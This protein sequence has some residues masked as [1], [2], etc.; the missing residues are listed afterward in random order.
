M[1]KRS[2]IDPIAALREPS[3]L[4]FLVGSML[5]NTGNQ[6][7][8]AAVG[9]EVYHRTH[10]PIN[11]GYV[12][13]V[14]A[15]PVILLAMPAG[16]AADRYSRR[17]IIMIAQA[18]L[19]ISGVGLA[20]AS[21]SH[22]PLGWV[23]LFLLSTGTFRALGWPAA[24]AIVTGLVPHNVFAN[25]AMWRSVGFQLAST[26]GPLMG[27]FLIAWWNPVAIYLID[28]ASSLIL[29]GCLV[30]VRPKAHQRMAEPHSWRSL[31]QGI[32]YLRRNPVIL[33]TMTLDMVAVLFGGATALLPIYA[34]EVLHVGATG[35]GW[36]RAMPSIGAIAMSVW[37]AT[38]PPM[39]RGG[40]TLL[41]AVVAFGLATIVFGLSKSYPLSLAA[42][43]ALG[44]A[45]NVSVVIRS[46][47]L[48]LLTPDSMR[49]RV[50]A[51]GVIFIGTSNEIGELESGVAAQWLGLLPAVV[52]G[53]FMT[54]LTVGAV[55]KAWPELTRL[56]SLE[57]LEPPEQVE[58]VVG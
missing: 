11:L 26:L 3:Y 7:R 49:G 25:A 10:E 13:L 58:Q 44:A 20:W 34:T 12:G 6:M 38:H 56:G 24:T 55:A 2:E 53:G 27:G 52:G 19:A 43:F 15:L 51:V 18:G 40:T 1:A 28:A 16:A 14:L 54:L 31:L 45:D 30:F 47:V 8:A 4:L 37:M 32:H 33:S 23:Y 29:V 17:A 22:A 21:Y 35:F 36:L 9:W 41:W 39:R 5:S 46:T 57:H 48:Q 50:S 42:L